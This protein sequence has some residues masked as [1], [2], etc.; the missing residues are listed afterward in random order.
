VSAERLKT[1]RAEVEALKAETSLAEEL[2]TA[3]LAYQVDSTPE[4]KQALVAARIKIRNARRTAR[5]GDQ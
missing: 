5:G 2:V 1:L 4:N 3:K